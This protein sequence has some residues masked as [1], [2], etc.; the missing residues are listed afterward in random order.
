MRTIT[1]LIG[2]L[3][4]RL[5]IRRAYRI[6]PDGFFSDLKS[7]YEDLQRRAYD[8][9]RHL[10]TLDDA[11][12]TLEYADMAVLG[13]GGQEA[14]AK[15]WGLAL[16]DDYVAFCSEF[17]EYVLATR[18]PVYT[19]RSKAIESITRGLREGRDIPWKTEHRL[20]YFAQIVGTCGYFVFRWSKARKR[21]DIVL[22]ED[23]GEVGEPELLGKDGDSY[24]TD[25]DFTAWLQRMID[26]DGYPLK[27]GRRESMNASLTRIK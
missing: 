19:E 15:R 7:E 3:K 11:K 22:A 1:E 6:K 9:T 2:I 23:Y 14:L 24:V 20:F 26:T 13:S 10:P 5:Q 4:C 27:P 8:P 21:V 12:T 16:P 25:V 18:N 17:K